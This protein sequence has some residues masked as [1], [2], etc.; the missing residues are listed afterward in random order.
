MNSMLLTVSTLCSILNID[1]ERAK[2][3]KVLKKEGNHNFKK[4]SQVCVFKVVV[5]GLLNYYLVFD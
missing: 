2:F 4:A 3:L 5:V 1:D